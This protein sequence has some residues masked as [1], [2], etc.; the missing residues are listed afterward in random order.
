MRYVT[1]GI[2]SWV[3]YFLSLAALF[4]LPFVIATSMGGIWLTNSHFT[5]HPRLKFS[6]RCLLRYT[7]VRG[8]EKLWTCSDAFNE[9]LLY[10]HAELDTLPFFT[11]YEEDRDS[12][13]SVDCVTIVLGLPVNSLGS[14]VENSFPPPDEMDAI[15]RVEFIP[16]FIYE[17]IHPSIHLNMTAAPLIVF[18]RPGGGH[19]S[20]SGTGGAHTGGPV[21]ASTSGDILFH[22]TEPLYSWSNVHY[23]HT[24]ADSPLDAV[25]SIDD[26]LNVPRFA[27][28]YASRNQSLLFRRYAES[29]GG[30]SLLP[31]ITY[32]RVLGED[33]DTVGDFTWKLT[34]RVQDANV[35]YVSSIPELIK[36]AWIQYFTIAYVI[37]WVLWK[38]RGMLLKSGMIG[39]TA[40]FHRGYA[41][42]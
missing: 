8:K 28:K 1:R 16:E 35:P 4:I 36:W 15:E 41:P 23:A 32:D 22:T 11:I 12:D 7:T 5:Q 6:G 21:C 13:G 40:I 10:G 31:D 24:Y 3:L 2:G 17:I 42:R 34:L 26:V 29:A 20:A 18:Q 9:K 14:R 19:A 39:S 27:Q 33:M 38:L 25:E 37:Q 30:A